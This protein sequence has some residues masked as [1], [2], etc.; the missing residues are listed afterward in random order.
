MDHRD[1]DHRASVRAASRQRPDER[2]S[3]A[4]RPRVVDDD[5]LAHPEARIWEKVDGTLCIVYLDPYAGAWCVATRSVPDADR[6][7]DGFGDHTFRSLFEEAV[8]QRGMTFAQF[9]SELD[10]SLTYCFELT[11]PRAGSGVVQYAGEAIHLLAVRDNATGAELCP[12]L[13][14]WLPAVASHPAMGLDALRSMIEGRSPAE[15]EGVVLRLPGR[16]SSGGYRRVKVKSTAYVAAHGLS[17]DAGASPRNLLRII[18]KGMWDDVAPL[19][20]VHL[21]ERGDGLRDSFVTWTAKTDADYSRLRAEHGGDRKSFALAIQA[22]GLPMGPLMSMWQGQV[23]STRGWADSRMQ[24]GDW[25]DGF[26]DSLA[27]YL[28]S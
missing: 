27:A 15:A 3:D 2:L 6:Q 8:R 24:N 22:A 20:K 19:C 21:R 16:T 7:I 5:A 23:E 17:S 14:A 25:G 28:A 10:P 18:L 4:P 13:V 26:L 1:H 11:S 9:A 12:T